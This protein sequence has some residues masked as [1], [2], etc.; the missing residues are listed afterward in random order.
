MTPSRRALILSLCAAPIRAQER[1]D[2]PDFRTQVDVVNIVCTVRNLRGGYVSGLNAG[3]FRVFEDNKEQAIRYFSSEARTPFTVALMIDVSG[4]VSRVLDTEKRAALGF[5]LEV[6]RPTD[7]AL[8]ASFSHAISI[9]QELT[10]DRISLAVAVR[11][12]HPLD[13]NLPPE[14]GA[15]GGTLLYE[16]VKLVSELKLAGLP[17]RKAV[18]VITDGVDN[19]SLV[20]FEAAL[21]AVQQADAVFYG[22]HYNGD[23][24]GSAEGEEILYRLADPTGGREFNAGIVNPLD[25]IFR[26]IREEM[27]SQYDLG[28]VSSNRA[29]DGKYRRLTVKTTRSVLRVRARQGYF[30]PGA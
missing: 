19:G 23:A 27:R 12:I 24:S 29:R 11:A 16:G 14:K 8:V 26:T 30:A 7:R 22:I 13:S 4:S 20:T 17:G 1:P 9:N 15:H 5:L 2:G 21:R 28:Y 25:S 10:S 6:L 3:D 18:V